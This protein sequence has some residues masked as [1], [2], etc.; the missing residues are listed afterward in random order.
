MQKKLGLV[1]VI[2]T[3]VGLIVATGCFLTLSQGAA[4]VGASFGLAML[5]AGAINI[6]TA[7]SLGELNAVLPNL[8]G[9]LA[10]YT[11]AS[12]GPF[13]AVVTMV[14]GYLVCN[15]V[16]GSVEVAMF[17]NVISTLF[18]SDVPTVVY[19]VGVLVV[20]VITNL[21]GLDMFAKVQNVVAYSLIGLMLLMGILGML[22]MGTGEVVE[23]ELVLTWDPN[24]VFSL[25]GLAFF[26]FLGCEFIIPISKNVKNARV[27][28]PLGMILSIVIVGIMD[29]IVM[30]GM[31][32]YTDWSELGGSLAPH[33][34][35]GTALLGDTGMILMA[36]VSILAA[37][38]SVN[39]IMNGL[40]YICDG[41][42]KIKL[43]PKVFMN[44]NKAGAPF[45]GI[46]LV[47]GAMIVINATGLSNSSELS[48][49]ILIGCVFWMIA[50]I[51]SSL[52][53][54]VLRKKL[55][56]APRTFKVP[57]GPVI[58]I[59]GIAGNLFMI[60]NIDGDPEVKGQIYL[61]TFILFAIISVMA[62]LWIKLALK[63]KLF[64]PYEVKEVMAMENEMYHIVRK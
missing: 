60:W 42:A 25:V 8:T 46:L 27:N 38:S 7:L 11:L 2:A 16:C 57:L 64:K 43:L 15:I 50:Y 9:G 4:A 32:N 37:V 36:L 62:I 28:V 26:L 6:F 44:K 48:F 56:K 1:S 55:P 10:Q 12:F 5:I 41:M 29:V 49:F 39:S 13:V 47:G 58:P 33:L 20:L 22:N 54:L 31:S 45:V 52:N 34:F 3:G 18:P 30:F 24:E 51:I 17:G 53:V 14:G 23:Q 35:Y 19:C 61:I 21:C 63:R 40:A 59:L